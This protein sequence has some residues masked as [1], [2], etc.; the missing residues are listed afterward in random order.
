MDDHSHEPD[1]D[2]RV[3]APM[4]EFGS[5]EV[6]VGAAVTL[7]GLLIAYAVPFLATF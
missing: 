2:K 7:V 6:G 5:R 4:Q 1:P 3:T